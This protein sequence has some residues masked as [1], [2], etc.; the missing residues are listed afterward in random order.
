M[1]YKIFN[2]VMFFALIMLLAEAV[3]ARQ[4]EK[5]NSESKKLSKDIQKEVS[6][7]L[8]KVSIELKGIDFEELSHAIASA[9][10]DISREL[11]RI[12]IH[13][14]PQ[15]PEPAEYSG[16]LAEKTKLISKTYSVGRNDKLS[17]DNLYGKVAVHT[18]AK[19][20]IKISVEIKAYESS[21][22][23]AAQLL[24]SV[25]IDESRSGDLISFKTSFEKTSVN[26]WSRMRNGREEKR[27]VQVN[28][29]I[30]M[31]ARNPLDITNRYGSTEID[32]FNGPVNISSSYG[33]FSSGSLDN[34][35]NQVKI[36]YGSASI[37][38]FSKGKLS[39][40]YGSLKL[41]K[42]ND[43]SANIR[44]S[45]ARIASL[46]VGGTFN[47]AY[48]GG[49]KI[50]EVEKNV[51][52][53]VINS[54]Y[55]GLTLGIKEG[56]D[57]DFDVTVSYAGF[58]FDDERVNLID[59]IADSSKPKSWSPTKNYK[60]SIGKGSDSRIIIKSNYGSVKFL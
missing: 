54:S 17:I 23:S 4:T 7:A 1:K 10:R 39:V 19:N 35:A 46:S 9:G 5:Q 58:N 57:F 36:T 49:F 44:Y 43:L 45:S 60:G 40:A 25:N 6:E 11:N 59:K 2:R 28:Y 8:K 30:F 38:N 47:I 13:A 48:T 14:F 3:S 32:D 51:K 33:S 53:L 56:A 21:E 15:P 18:W 24:E 31:P 16:V 29:E 50:D 37:S 26:F 55:S 42:G 27:G 12:E 52:N 20:E 22:S 34:A 41:D